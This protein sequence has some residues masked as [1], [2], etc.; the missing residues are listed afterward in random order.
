MSM[1]RLP[2]YLVIDCSESMAG[3]AIEAVNRGVEALIAEL[4]SVPQALE[5]AF[6]S[7]ITF[8]RSAEQVMPLT[9]LLDVHVPPF[10]V[11]SG[12]ALGAALRLLKQSLETEVRKT[13]PTVKGD[14]RPLVFLL[15]DGQPTDAWEQ[16]AEELSRGK[17]TRPANIYA[18]GCGEDVDT[19]V[20]YRLTD[21][22]LLMPDMSGPAFKKLFVWMTA[23]V[24]S[25]SMLLDM[26]EEG[27]SL[28][29]EVLEVA[30]RSEPRSGGRARQV[31]LHAWCSKSKKPYLMRYV[32]VAGGMEY[33][34]TAAHQL[35]DFEES[36]GEGLPPVDAS[37]LIGCPSCPYCGNECA[38]VCPCGALFC[39]PAGEAGVLE[40]PRCNAVLESGGPA[41]GRTKVKR[42]EG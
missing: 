23:S 13:T 14:Y 24:S 30:P 37:S 6:L 42:S 36:E 41:G 27:P 39:T 10:K 16:A 28:P 34:A 35:E 17:G 9:E 19:G 11:R 2:I 12:T 4:R 1:R 20:L 31:F 3:P 33:M 5:T 25:A 29:E 38:G 32:S 21:V 40:C 8:S 7:I 15:T 26:A 18:I 22:V